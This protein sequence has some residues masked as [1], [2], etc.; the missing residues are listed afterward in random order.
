[1]PK[2]IDQKQAVPPILSLKSKSGLL[3]ITTI[4]QITWHQLS[5]IQRI[6]ISPR[7]P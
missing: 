2:N 3:N 4:L 6:S 1:M 5:I 7:F